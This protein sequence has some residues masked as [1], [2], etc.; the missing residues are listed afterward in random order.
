M[1]EPPKTLLHASAEEETSIRTAVRSVRGR[2]MGA[3]QRL[4][5][6]D[7]AAAL[8]EFFSDPRVSD[9]IYSLPRPFTAENVRA[10]LREC[11]EA[12]ERGEDIMLLTFDDT[13]RVIGYSEVVVWPQHSAAELIGA[14]RADRQ[15]SR[16]GGVGMQNTI[17]WIF[18]G[19]G[20]RM[21]CLTAA[22]DN[23]RSQALIDRAGF[24]RMGERDGVR[25][26]GTRRPSVYWEMTRE[27]WRSRKAQSG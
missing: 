21:M 14:I 22:L 12:S 27:A 23:V 16:G 11:I 24:V 20:V 1:S 4:A 6:E 26:D 3:L 17:N 19:L 8:A 9:P 10:W 7:D 18:E 2:E 25:R 15:N 5:R 13:G